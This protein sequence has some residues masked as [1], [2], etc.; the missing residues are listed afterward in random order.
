MPVVFYTEEE[1]NS[2]LVA[3]KEKLMKLS[4]LLCAQSGNLCIYGETGRLDGP[5]EYC[6][7][8]PSEK[9]CPAFFKEYSQ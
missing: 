5:G 1:H 7:N 3:V 8:C 2:E 4:Q 9:Y 6:D